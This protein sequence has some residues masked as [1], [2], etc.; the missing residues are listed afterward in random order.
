MFCSLSSAK[1]TPS[2][3]ACECVCVE[4]FSCSFV[5]LLLLFFLVHHA[6]INTCTLT[7]FILT[8]TY[9]LASTHIITLAANLCSENHERYIQQKESEYL[10]G[11]NKDY[12]VFHYAFFFSFRRPFVHFRLVRVTEK[13]LLILAYLFMQERQIQSTVFWVLAMG[14][15]IFYTMARPFRAPASN[16]VLLICQYTLCANTLLLAG[17]GTNFQAAIF[18]NSQLSVLL[19]ALNGTGFMLAL[20]VFV[21]A[22]IYSRCNPMVIDPINQ[23]RGTASVFRPMVSCLRVFFFFLYTHTHTHTHIIYIY[24]FCEGWRE[25]REGSFTAACRSPFRSNL[26]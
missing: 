24:T 2:E 6:C 26:Q 1:L 3:K 10:L 25:A 18:L 12:I 21:G 15:A 8:S 19:W 20:L 23:P 9:Q 16:V 7:C 13:I 22:G 11:I 14:F 17:K 4:F 5:L